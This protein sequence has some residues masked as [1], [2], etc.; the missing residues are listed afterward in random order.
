MSGLSQAVPFAL[1]AAVY[2]PAILVCA[3]L[4]TG[5]RPRLLLGSYFVGAALV[6][7]SAGIAGLALLDGVGASR[8]QSHKTAAGVD[9]ALGLVLLAVAA[10]VWPRRHRAAKPAD[11]TAGPGRIAQMS[12]RARASARW[13][14]ALGIAMYLPSPLYLAAIKQIA[15]TGG[16][17][18]G[19]IAAILICAACVMLF[20]EVPLVWLLLAPDGLADRLDRLQAAIVRS[21]W[22]I[23]AA[24][25]GVAGAYLLVSGIA[26]VE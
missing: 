12:E 20:V 11:P 23:G 10:W 26:H 5:D 16:V 9:I 1:A 24:L 21:S 19:N 8:A 13:A 2:P 15:D 3:L 4:L 14:F 17:T 18:A 22:T 6:T 25:A 7:V